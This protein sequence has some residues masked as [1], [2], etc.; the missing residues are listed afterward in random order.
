VPS[1]HPRA[2]KS[3]MSSSTPLMEEMLGRHLFPN[4]TIH[5]L[6]GVKHDNRPENLALWIRPQPNGI[7]VPDA[8]P[9]RSRFW[10]GT[11]YT[12]PPTAIAN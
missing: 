12:P 9:G 4:E 8:V 1:D 2:G 7:R 5:H 10:S 11:G 6:N 3:P